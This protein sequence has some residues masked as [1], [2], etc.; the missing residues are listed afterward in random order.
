MAKGELTYW[1]SWFRFLKSTLV[2]SLMK[3]H[4]ITYTDVDNVASIPAPYILCANHINFWDPFMLNSALSERIHYIVSDSNFRAPLRR[5]FLNMVGSIPKA[6]STSDVRTIKMILQVI[7]E[8]GVIGL[9]PEG[10]R[11]WE[12]RTAPIFFSAAKLIKR[13]KIPVITA[14]IKGAFFSKPRWSSRSSHGK[15]EI[16][17]HLAFTPEDL[18]KTSEEKIQ[19]KLTLLLKHDEVEYQKTAQTIYKGDHKAEGLEYAL[20]RCPQCNSL[21]T[22]TGKGNALH[23]KHCGNT[24][25]ISETWAFL[26]AN[27]QDQVTYDNIRDWFDWQDTILRKDIENH[28]NQKIKKEFFSD[29]GAL[30]YHLQ[31]PYKMILDDQGIAKMTSEGV[32]LEGKKGVRFFPLTEIKASNI[33]DDEKLEFKVDNITY[34]LDFSG[35]VSAVKW[36]KAIKHFKEL[37]GIH[38]PSQVS[39]L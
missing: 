28:L 30:L 10:I 8:K 15:I 36:N 31:P 20:Y 29:S 9:F 25:K 7:R 32:Y 4:K 37:Q 19:E 18:E 21:S 6:K 2:P 11:S 27:S 34:R 22:L 14:R 12:G 33:Q 23:C 38:E 24:I 16:E 1:K 17:Y 3:R 39:S 13:L 5:K 26:P 35:K